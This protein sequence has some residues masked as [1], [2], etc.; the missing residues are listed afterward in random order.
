MSKLRR[1][2]RSLAFSGTRFGLFAGVGLLLLAAS[3]GSDG[4]SNGSEAT[5]GDSGNPEAG[6]TNTGA[7]AGEATTSRGGRSSRG[8]STG[9]GGEPP[10]DG[11]AGGVSGDPDGL[12]MPGADGPGYD[13][14]DLDSLDLQKPPTGCVG[15]FDP[16][17]ETLELSL[18]KTV[19]VVLVAVTN[20]VLTANGT[21]CESAD[22]VP[23][24][25]DGLTIVTI[26]GGK[27]A[28]S[29]Y[30][31][32]SSEF[33]AGLLSAGGDFNVDLGAGDDELIVLGSDHADSILLGNE[34]DTVWVDF[35]GDFEPD[36]RIVGV[37]RALVS[38]GPKPDVV[39]C[40]GVALSADPLAIPV[41]LFGG[42]ANDYLLGGAA[43][44]QLHG[45]I[46][47]DTLDAGA[48]AGGADEYDGGP[49]EDLVDYSARVA[50][51]VVTLA[52]IAD[53]GEPN[54][55]DDVSSTIEDV[56][57]AQ[58]PNT[59][60]G[61]PI[62]NRIWGGPSIDVIQG[63]DGSDIIYGGDGDDDIDGGNGDDI[64]YGDEGDDTLEGNSGDDLLDGYPGKNVVDGGTGDADICSLT[65]NDK[66]TG[67]EL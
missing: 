4:S 18:D 5:G 34:S 43:D 40:N 26:T 8:G 61:S 47:N 60:A 20:G 10:V 7:T 3:C 38:T 46:G 49:G 30:V 21:A 67:C 25:T 2:R 36:V 39:L 33:G 57:G 55:G 28:N 52:G 32:T 27:E 35:S 59:I 45:G 56:I 54:E 1:H 51:V 19:P 66:G 65:K 48:D 23:A 22:G 9:V 58:G 53:D 63:G 29:V 44:D 24:S 15:G 14:V 64:I 17:S 6:A 11:G 41:K 16:D 13:G 62:E 31:D 42:G 12:L 37:E 50:G